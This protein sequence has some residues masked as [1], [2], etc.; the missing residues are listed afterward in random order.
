MDRRL[1][2]FEWMDSTLSNR[3]MTIPLT[4]SEYT[5][6]GYGLGDLKSAQHTDM[7][8]RRMEAVGKK[9]IQSDASK[10]SVRIE[11]FQK[12][13]EQTPTP[14][15]NYK[16]QDLAAAVKATLHFKEILSV[17][18]NTAG[19]SFSSI[20]A[21]LKDM[22][23]VMSKEL[24]SRPEPVE[25]MPEET[26]IELVVEEEE[27]LSREGYKPLMPL[28]DAGPAAPVAVIPIRTRHEAYRQLE[29]IAAF[30]KKNDPHSPAH[31][32]L[33]QLILWENKNIIDIFGEVSENSQELAI[34]MKL[35][36][37]PALKE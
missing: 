23:R 36:G 24:Q 26:A 14:V 5:Q 10:T 9:A 6:T 11:D 33:H 16:Q 8:E 15:V 13:L 37:N 17:F 18:L 1:M 31:Q 20:L 12:A 19:P 28:T 7:I 32:L 3:L 25:E 34:L 4:Q 27:S 35:L 2:V 29:K 30:L 22:E 21:T